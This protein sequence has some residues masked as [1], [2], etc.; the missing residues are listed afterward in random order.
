MTKNLSKRA[1]VPPKSL[2]P[3]PLLK[4]LR[5]LIESARERVATQVNAEITLL[6]W[7]IGERIRKDILKEKRAG[8]G[9]EILPTLSA[10]LELE[11][12]KGFDR[13]NLSRMVKFA[14]VFPEF[15]IVGTLCQQLSWSH[16]RAIISL[17]DPLARDFYAEMCRIERWSVR[18]LRAKI[19]GMLFERTGIAKK[20][21]ELARKELAHLREEDQLSPD[22][23][24]R[25]PYLLD[26]LQLSDAFSE[27]DL[28]AAILREL[29]RFLLEIG[30]DFAFVSRQKRITVD[31]EDY[32]I[33]LLFYHRRLARLV[34]IE[35]KMG[36]FKPADK[37]QVELYLRW[38]DKHE[39][40]PAEGSPIG[41]ILCAGRSEEHI[42]LLELER[43]GIRVAEYLTELPPRDVLEKRL[44]EAILA[45]KERLAITLGKKEP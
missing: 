16:F 6:Y 9:E 35:L 30:T 25:D 41:L 42:E 7:R 27:R 1:S 44:H 34:V 37:G 39:R 2:V 22:L 5:G 24:F 29:E 3:K 40:Q 19:D 26:F 15:E 11:F 12:G 32:Y 23:V 21:D 18:T 36:K 4:D 13:T 31:N 45:A 8:Y 17:D 43:S 28:E 10:K 38:L 33:D 20:P 14:D